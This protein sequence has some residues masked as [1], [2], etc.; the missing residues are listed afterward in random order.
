MFDFKNHREKEIIKDL[1]KSSERVVEMKKEI[2][3]H[4][5]L[6]Q[7]LELRKVFAEVICFI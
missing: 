1:K 6:K 7:D 5:K 3:Q 2:E 4:Q